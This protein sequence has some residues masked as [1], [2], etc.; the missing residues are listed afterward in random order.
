[1]GVAGAAHRRRIDLLFVV[2]GFGLAAVCGA[3]AAGDLPAWERGLF[4]AINN[5]SHRFELATWPLQQLGMALAIPLGAAFLWRRVRHWG[6][7]TALL[8]M[9]TTI[10]WGTANVIRETVERGRPPSFLDAVQLGYDVPD[11]GPAFPSGHAIVVWTLIVVLAPYV[12][13]RAVVVMSVLAAGVMVSRVYVGAHMPLDVVGGALYGVGVGGL[14]NLLGGI[15][16]GSS[17]ELQVSDG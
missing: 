11:A 1:M 10:G 13:R 2:A 5:L 14:T 15:R 4:R 3:F 6:P 17:V 9:A 7:P 12:S 8:A 16:R